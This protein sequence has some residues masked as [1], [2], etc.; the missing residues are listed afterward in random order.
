MNKGPVPDIRSL[1]IVDSSH[2][3]GKN[4]Y[5]MSRLCGLFVKGIRG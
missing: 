4:A 5:I 3:A 2:S 1:L